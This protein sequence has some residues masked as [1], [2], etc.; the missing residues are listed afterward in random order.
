[1]AIPSL[2]SRLLDNSPTNKLL[3]VSSRSIVHLES[4]VLQYGSDGSEIVSSR[5]AVATCRQLEWIHLVLSPA[6][7]RPG[8]NQEAVDLESNLWS[9]CEP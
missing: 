8:A 4:K 1:M 3:A 6:R 9:R 7:S 2:R 5:A